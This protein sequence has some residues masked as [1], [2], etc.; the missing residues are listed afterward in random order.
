MWWVHSLWAAR[1]QGVSTCEAIGGM[2][3]WCLD[4]QAQSRS[5]F[6]EPSARW[7]CVCDL[8]MGWK[9]NLPGPLSFPPFSPYLRW[10]LL[11]IRLSCS[12]RASE[13]AV[14][15][16]PIRQKTLS[17][18]TTV[19]TSAPSSWTMT[20]LK[21]VL[22][23]Q[24]LS[25]THLPVALTPVA[26]VLVSPQAGPFW[27]RARGMLLAPWH[28]CFPEPS[29][30]VVCTTSAPLLHTSS[31]GAPGFP[32]GMSACFNIKALWANHLLS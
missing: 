31:E 14:S 2:G 26:S 7:L 12:R 16:S 23:L 8:L 20:P 10:S 15:R 30:P 25:Y 17:S 3:W 29:V 1:I 32:F 24:P 9:E 13:Q 28:I 4:W 5:S 21:W 18:I 6:Q 11:W 19:G 22:P 27:V